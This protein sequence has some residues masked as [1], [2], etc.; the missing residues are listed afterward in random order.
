MLSLATKCNPLCKLKYQVARVLKLFWTKIKVL[1]IAT[2]VI[3]IEKCCT[4]SKNLHLSVILFENTSIRLQESWNCFGTANFNSEQYSNIHR[5]V[6]SIDDSYKW[7]LVFVQVGKRSAPLQIISNEANTCFATST[8]M[9]KIIQK[10]LL[11]LFQS[12]HSRNFF[13]Q[14]VQGLSQ[15]YFFKCAA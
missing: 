14:M 1:T 9:T 2:S 13:F 12:L 10:I 8:L 15:R 6:Q 4:A 7:Y 3:C 5:W 11:Q